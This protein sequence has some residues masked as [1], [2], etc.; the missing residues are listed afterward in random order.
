M[1]KSPGRYT[2]PS[3]CIREG[4]KACLPKHRRRQGWVTEDQKLS[5]MSLVYTA[6]REKEGL[7]II[8]RLIGLISRHPPIPHPSP[9]ISLLKGREYQKTDLF[10]DS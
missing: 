5:S 1:L 2:I 10:S 9:E 8:I 3:L 7:V 6:R 4:I